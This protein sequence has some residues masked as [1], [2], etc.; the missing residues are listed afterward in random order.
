MVNV[1]KNLIDM[2]K[3]VIAH[4]QDDLSYLQDIFN[5]LDEKD[6]DN[7]NSAM[8][9]IL[10]DESL[11]LSEKGN[12]LENSWKV[13]HTFHITPEEFLTDKWI[14][15]MS[16]DLYPHIKENFLTFFNPMNGKNIDLLYDC[17]GFGKSTLVGLL[18]LYRAVYTLSLRNPKQYFKLAKSTRLTDTSVS[19]TKS[20][21]YDLVLKPMISIMENSTMFHKL[22]YERDM[23]NPEYTNN[24]KILWCNTSNG[25]SIIRIGDVYF[26][27]ASDP[28]DLVGRTILN[29]SVTEMS[30]L[31]EQMPEERVMRMLTDGIN[32]VAS[33]FGYNNMETTIIVDSSP[34]SME[35]MAD[36]WVAQHKNDKNVL[37]S[38]HNKWS[39]Q[40]HLFPIYE[41]DN[42]KVFTMF[43][44]NMAKPCKI[45]NEDEKKNYNEDELIDLPI[46]LY[47]VAKDTPSKILKD[48]GAVPSGGNDLKLITNYD[49]IEDAF[50]PNLK[51]F[52]MYDH[53]PSSLPS[54]NLLWDIVKKSGLFVYSGV[55]NKYNFYRNP[56]AVRFLSIDL[57]R[58]HD[59]AC[60]SMCHL[61]QNIKGEKIY[62]IDF[63]LAIMA[64][65]E[66]INMDA[67]RYLIR[68]LVVYGNITV[69][70]V[71]LDGFQSDTTIQYLNRIGIDCEKMSV[72]FPIEP[73]LS[74]ISALTQRRVKMGRNIIAKNNYKS[75]VYSKTQNGKGLHN[76]I[77]HIQGEWCDLQNNDFMTSRCGANGKDLVDT[78]VA[79]CTLADRY[80]TLDPQY[81]FNEQLEFEKAN[82][83][84]KVFGDE[85]WDKLGLKLAK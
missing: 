17:I 55:G 59:M 67:F 12:L 34:N 9:V 44:G 78:I 82:H 41:K 47:D 76:K 32:R 58:S 54:E 46:D 20:T 77:D 10:N 24:G 53:A 39:I 3:D 29:F 50:T 64:T 23:T 75:L 1:D 83:N 60:I 74:H 18:K 35:G 51:N 43:K 31:C 66:E 61:E 15:S 63:T 8:K 70:K 85:I 30:F 6:I 5:I 72:D 2:C 65:K 69:G 73:Y 80:G 42:S 71:S 37:Y 28:S 16:E 19:F 26:D 57:A 40:P 25:N 7:I 48:Y 21:C 33:R 22:R 68:D 52:L 27:V 62:I 13:N 4:P 79:C 84:I 49:I 36:Q 56:F 45:I 11:S 81:I 38:N 14:G